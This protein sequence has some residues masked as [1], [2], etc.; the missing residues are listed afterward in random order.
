MAG[1]VDSD[2]SDEEEEGEKRRA[3]L[4]KRWFLELLDSQILTLNISLTLQPPSSLTS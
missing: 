2:D 4:V 3:G 1:D